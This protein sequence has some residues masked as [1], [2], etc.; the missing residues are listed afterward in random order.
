MS[1]NKHI[2]TFPP[3]YSINEKIGRNFIQQLF[4][5]SVAKEVTL[6][7]LQIE[8]KKFVLL[9]D[10]DGNKYLLSNK[11]SNL[12]V[13]SYDKI[14]FSKFDDIIDIQANQSLTY[15]WIKHPMLNS[16]VDSAIENKAKE[17]FDSWKDVFNFK[18]EDIATEKEGLRSPQLG[19]IHASLAHWSKSENLATIV[20]PTG[21]GKTEVML[22]LLSLGSCSKL[23]VT[24]P[25]D[26]LRE[27]LSNKFLSF[28]ILKKIGVLNNNA[29]LP[30]VGILNS[31]LPNKDAAASFFKKCNVVVST[32]NIVTKAEPVIQQEIIKS[33][34][35]LFIDE[36]H[37]SEAPSWHDFRKTFTNCVLQFT[38]TPFREDGKRLDGDIIYNYPLKKAQDEG[39]FKKINFIALSEYDPDL[40]DEAI[41]NEAIKQLKKDL[42]KGYDHILMAR[43]S[44]HARANEIYEIYKQYPEHNPVLIHTGIKKI[45]RDEIRAQI[46][47]KKTQ[48]IVCVDMLGEGFDLPEL[49]IAAFHDIR[50]SLPITLQLA[51]RFTRTR[52]D[53]KLGEATFIAN[54]GDNTLNEKIDDLYSYDSDWNYLLQIK[55]ENQIKEEVDYKDFL[56][57]F[58]GFKKLNISLQNLFPAMSTVVYKNCSDNCNLKNY[59]KGLVG[60]KKSDFITDVRSDEDKTLV[61]VTAQKT[62]IEWGK[63]KDI[64]DTLW[65]LYVVY[66]DEE[67]K[68][69][70][71]HCSDKGSMYP[72][73]AHAI[74]GDSAQLIR[75]MDV[76]KAL[77]GINRLKLQN[78]GLKEVIGKLIRYTSRNGTDIAEA[79][80][81][82]E[83][84]KATKAVI[85]GVGFENGVKSSMGCSYKG[86]IWSKKKS[87]LK[88]LTSWCSEVGAK[89]INENIDPNEILKNTFTPIAISARP[90]YFPIGIEWNVFIYD[91]LENKF[92]FNINGLDIPLYQLDIELTK[93]NNYGN[94]TFEIKSELISAEFEI[95]LFEKDEVK[96]F[97]IFRKDS[98]QHVNV[99]YGRHKVAAESFFSEY[100][101][102][103]W[104]VNGSSLSGNSYVDIK[105][106]L[107]P[108]NSENIIPRDWSGVDLRKESQGIDPKITDSIQYHLLQELKQGDYDIIYDDDNSGEI[109]DI[110]T[111]KK[112]DTS[113][114][115]ELYHLKFAKNGTTGKDINDL[116]QVCGQSQK[117]VNWKF[118]EGNELFDHML[119]R[120]TKK[121]GMQHCSR[122]EKGN[123]HMLEK[124]RSMAKNSFNIDW[125]VYVVQPSITKADMSVSQLELLGVTE[126]Y[127]KQHAISFSVIGSA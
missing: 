77:N 67:K 39:Y 112:L 44:S 15:E 75:G 18:L 106:L 6:S 96:D 94:I 53:D 52:Q 69:L 104:F 24:V 33:F 7:D 62:S 46:L 17:A 54:R 99:Y 49:K 65:N 1:S 41:A 116:Y 83:K 89:L 105:N 103:I 109:A 47:K 95:E 61:I 78:V 91:Q 28:G 10:E 98:T 79:L 14:I 80:S 4:L 107:P 76:F 71:I 16:Y 12:K 51:G 59:R 45:K 23:L 97:P 56:A 40:A 121:K 63:I 124:F 70:F 22:S 60:Y 19:A 123:K 9:K 50:K 29:Q 26:P 86:R 20:M 38:A 13:D 90:D 58:T 81:D 120:E 8:K 117:C 27:Q 100:P 119:R 118:K 3:I 64:Y 48:I 68:L 32:V 93:P 126:S 87:N 2:F 36:A 66:Y 43:V 84:R 115:V 125:R 111:I 72:E 82:A 11:R 113:F 114:C 31:S 92:T 127:L 102:N 73:L 57:R 101:P 30:V 35:H 34:S 55:S 25:T 108:F 5:P 21:T 42:K 37:H 88:E 85:F 110:I 122:I 74:I